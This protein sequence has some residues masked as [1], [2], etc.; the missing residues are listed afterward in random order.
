MKKFYFLLTAIPLLFQSQNSVEHF[1]GYNFITAQSVGKIKGDIKNNIYGHSLTFGTNLENRT[2]EWVKFLSAK[3][4]KYNL[5]YLDL[6]QMQNNLWGRNYGFGEVYA[7]SA[8]VDFRLMKFRDFEVLFSPT[9]GLA[10]ITK[11]VHTD[12]DSYFFGSHLNAMFDAGLGIQYDLTKNYALT[13][14]LSFLHFSNGAIQLPNAGVNT[15]SASIG[16]QRNFN[17]P[18]HTEQDQQPET[19]VKK[20]ALEIAIGVGQRGKYKVKEAFYRVAISP[21]YSYFIN[22]TLGFKIGLDAVYYDQVFNPEVYDDS[23]PYW[24]KSWEHWRIGTSVGTEIKMNKVS[25]NANYGYYLYFKSP[26]NQKTYWKAGLRY[27]FTPKLGA[28]SIMTAH[29][30]QA[31]FISFGLFARL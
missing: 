5:I 16:I 11:T 17:I 27:Y 19:Q 15:I 25:F 31:D 3:N 21:A 28:E 26:Y 23:V 2:E 29:Q 1:I 10:Y 12:P 18:T 22:N 4:I 14:R 24:G 30:V 6:D 8:N 9:L 20:Q 13:S 7:A